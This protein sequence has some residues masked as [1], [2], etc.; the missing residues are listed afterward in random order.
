MQPLQKTIC[1]AHIEGKQWKQELYSFLRN[2]RATPYSSAGV[3]RAELM[4]Q[5]EIN[6][7][8]PGIQNKPHELPTQVPAKDQLKKR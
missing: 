2:Y 3:S 6:I 7:H 5:R 1:A 4:F 8:L